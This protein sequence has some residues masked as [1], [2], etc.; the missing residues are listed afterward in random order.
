MAMLYGENGGVPLRQ[1]FH[2]E[3]TFT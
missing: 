2:Y 1:E 3:S